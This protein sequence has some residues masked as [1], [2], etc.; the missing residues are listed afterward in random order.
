[1]I[2]L[3]LELTV[4]QGMC[5]LGAIL[6]PNILHPGS[7]CFSILECS[8][9][10]TALSRESAVGAPCAEPTHSITHSKGSLCPINLSAVAGPSH[11]HWPAVKCVWD[12]FSCTIWCGKL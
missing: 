10:L 12:L 9:G 7:C 6:K 4:G 1:M 5:V 2:R 8:G 3:S 11:S